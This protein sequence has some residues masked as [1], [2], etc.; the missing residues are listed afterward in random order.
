ML[1][2]SKT[3]VPSWD[4]CFISHA[5][6]VFSGHAPCCG[7]G[8]AGLGLGL[9]G[10]RDISC[11]RLCRWSSSSLSVT[12]VSASDCPSSIGSPVIVLTSLVHPRQA[13]ELVGASPRCIFHCFY[14]GPA[15]LLP[16]SEAARKFESRMPLLCVGSPTHRY[17]HAL[18]LET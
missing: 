2:F 18:H 15:T 1:V 10:K 16:F 9:G 11:L 17:T 4:C 13:D 14:L 5:C 8:T 12:T 3:L 6:A 7:V